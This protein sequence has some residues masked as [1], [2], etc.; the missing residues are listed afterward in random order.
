MNSNQY[1]SLPHTTGGVNVGTRG[2][3]FHANPNNNTGT[4][5]VPRPNQKKKFNNKKNYNKSG[6]NIQNNNSN[7]NNNV[8]NC[9]NVK[10]QPFNNYTNNP[11]Y[12]HSSL[13]HTSQYSPS[14]YS[15]QYSAGK[16][17]QFGKFGCEDAPETLKS[18]GNNVPVPTMAK[19]SPLGN[20]KRHNNSNKH[21]RGGG[22]NNNYRG[23]G[24]F[25][26]SERLNKSVSSS[27]FYYDLITLL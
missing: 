16:F 5:Q 2:P 12:G 14:R 27:P 15:N 4:Q 25:T 13:P 18:F 11:D 3:S 21:K 23:N 20:T 26:E 7:N 6:N 8:N 17:G 24:P 10:Q 1:N 22:S 9:S 19:T